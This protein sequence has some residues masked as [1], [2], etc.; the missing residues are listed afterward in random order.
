MLFVFLWVYFFGRIF[1]RS[2]KKKNIFSWLKKLVNSQNGLF[3]VFSLKGVSLKNVLMGLQGL[4]L[5]PTV[6]AKKMSRQGSTTSTGSDGN[7]SR[8]VRGTVP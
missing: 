3:Q 4:S 7:S 5:M 6:Q 2:M 1:T 8:Y